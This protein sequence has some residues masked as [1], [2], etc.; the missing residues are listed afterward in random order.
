M[1][2]LSMSPELHKICR[3]F[4][5]PTLPAFQPQIV[6][7]ANDNQSHIPQDKQVDISTQESQNFQAQEV[8]AAQVGTASADRECRFDREA[9][10][11]ADEVPDVQAA[12]HAQQDHI[13]R[14]NTEQNNAL[15]VLPEESP[16][17]SQPIQLVDGELNENF[18]QTKY[19][20]TVAQDDRF[21]AARAKLRRKEL[22]YASAIVGGL[23]IVYLSTKLPTFLIP[24]DSISEVV[25][26][27]IMQ[28]PS[29]SV[30]EPTQV[31]LE[32]KPNPALPTQMVQDQSINWGFGACCFIGVAAV[33]SV[34]WKVFG[35]N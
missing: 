14:Q 22:V 7:V 34:L 12:Q 6:S 17:Q 8:P 25:K 35:S 33:G 5:K 13:V 30:I 26:P 15:C 2:R 23:V 18:D 31:S 20:K 19:L 16:S 10:D 21:E 11:M 24:R 27:L 32:S 9:Q 1:T 29:Q 28:Q 4:S 3:I